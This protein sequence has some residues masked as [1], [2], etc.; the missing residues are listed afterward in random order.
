MKNHRRTW[1]IGEVASNHGGDLKLAKEFIRRASES[2]LDYVKFQSWQASHLTRSEKDP[3]YEWFRRSELSDEAHHELMEECQ[4]KGIRFLTTVFHRDR[5][6]FLTSLGLEEIKVGSA[7]TNN[8]ELLRDLRGRFKRILISTGMA[9]HEEVEQAASVLEG[10]DFVFFHSVSLYPTPLEKVNL[11]RMDWLRQ[12]SDEVGYSDHSVG[13]EAA[14]LAIARGASYVEKHF[15]LD[16]SG[17]GRV[18]A[19]DATPKD[20]Q[21]LRQFADR[22]DDL[23]GSG[24]KDLDRELLKSR[25]FFIGRFR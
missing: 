4:K 11:H 17:P 13:L 20:M 19:W 14:K 21:E 15:C 6:P 16:R 10:E 2:G 9:T 24:R 8:F 3:Q 1:L 12:F 23:L 18:C 22:V 25:E 5:I 7:D